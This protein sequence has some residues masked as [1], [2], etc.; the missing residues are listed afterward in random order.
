VQPLRVEQFRQQIAHA[1]P[2][3]DPD[4]DSLS[5][6]TVTTP[7]LKQ[8]ALAVSFA[9]TK[10]RMTRRTVTST[11]GGERSRTSEQNRLPDWKDREIRRYWELGAEAGQ[12]SRWSERPSGFSAE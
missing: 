11:L 3:G 7:S 4:A 9:K 1:P 10:A 6:S 12:A 8:A 2:F 5:F